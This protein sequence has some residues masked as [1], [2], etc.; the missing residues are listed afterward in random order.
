MYGCVASLSGG[1]LQAQENVDNGDC[2]WAPAFAPDEQT[3]GTIDDNCWLASQLVEKKIDYPKFYMSCGT[4]DY[5]YP[6]NTELKEHL[7]RIGFRYDYHE[8]PGVHNWDFWDGE[9][10]RV[11]EWLPLQH[12]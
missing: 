4:E 7:D 6:K 11:L 5:I 9:I 8:Q 10:L 12:R 3:E 1:F 2:V